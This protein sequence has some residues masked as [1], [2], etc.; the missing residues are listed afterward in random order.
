[1]ELLF[2]EELVREIEKTILHLKLQGMQID[3][4]RQKR[5]VDTFYQELEGVI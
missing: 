1:M 5:A 2:N 4:S 3:Y